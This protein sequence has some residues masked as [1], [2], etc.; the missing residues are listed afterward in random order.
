MRAAIHRPVVPELPGCHG[1]GVVIAGTVLVGTVPR[2]TGETLARRNVPRIMPCPFG[3]APLLVK[4]DWHAPY[5]RDP[6]NQSLRRICAKRFQTFA[7][8][9]VSA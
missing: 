1:I 3:V 7:P 8:R 2:Y 5:H 6:V 9:A 4:Q